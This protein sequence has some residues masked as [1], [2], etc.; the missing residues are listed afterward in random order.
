MKKFIVL[1]LLCCVGTIIAGSV[2][3][4]IWLQIN[5]RFQSIEDFRKES[6]WNIDEV[7]EVEVTCG[8]ETKEFTYEEFFGLLG[9]GT[10][11][12]YCVTKFGD[13]GTVDVNFLE[14]N[15]PNCL[16]TVGDFLIKILKYRNEK[17]IK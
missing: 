11:E 7:I 12:I 9:F 6:T 4:K 1:L 10:R 8:V 5:T 17:E 16:M 13:D 14:P 2:T 15:D 3:K